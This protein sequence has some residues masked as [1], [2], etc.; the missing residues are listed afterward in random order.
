MEPSYNHTGISYLDFISRFHAFLTPKTYFE[1][2]TLQG[3]TLERSSCT[4]IAVD[5]DF[6]L[7]VSPT[8]N[9]PATLFF[10]MT[11]DHFFRHHS[12]S[13]LLGQPID[14]AFLDGLHQAETLLRDFSNTEK[15]CRPNSIIM[16][17]DCIPMNTEMTVREFNGGLWTGDVW[18][19]V[20]ILRQYRPDIRIYTFDAGPTGLV[21]CTGL[22][23][24]STV[25]DDQYFSIM[26][27]W[28]DIELSS[29]GFDRMLSEAEIRGTETVS[30]REFFTRYFWL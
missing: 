17:H 22:D 23:P 10:Q 21:C 9:R 20:P 5:P 16:M 28:E 7:S 24:R 18:K 14:L 27:K 3:S 29:Y 8:A 19:V 4:S 25:I 12:P 6:K 13:N 26:S 11:S 2:G 15:Y 1:I 30:K